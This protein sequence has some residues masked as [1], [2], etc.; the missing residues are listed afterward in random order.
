MEYSY[1]LMSGNGVNSDAVMRAIRRA[2]RRFLLRR[3]YLSRHVGDLVRLGIS[4]PT[5]AWH[6]TSRTFLGGRVP[7][8]N[9]GQILSAPKAARS[10]PH[11]STP[12]ARPGSDG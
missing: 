9:G 8:I 4:K 3:R 6:I 7:D 10:A 2:R 11:S 5:L 1:Y 12:I